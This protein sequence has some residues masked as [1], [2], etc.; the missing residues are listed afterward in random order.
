MA[1]ASIGWAAALWAVSVVPVAS[2][3][4]AAP[5]TAEPRRLV[6][7][8]R[9][10][11]LRSALSAVFSPRG[12]EV[13]ESPAPLRRPTDA[14][15]GDAGGA[16]PA[17]ADAV[18]LCEPESG[19]TALCVRPRR[20]QVIVR[21]IAMPTPLSAADA[22]S[23]AL[24][25][26]VALMPDE[27]APAPALAVAP[28]VPQA[29]IQATAA[30]PAPVQGAPPRLTV[31]L[32]AGGRRTA[33][34]AGLRGGVD[35]VYA[36]DA[37]ARRLGIG[38]GVGAG[39]AIAMPQPSSRGPGPAPSGGSEGDVTVRLFARGRLQLSAVRLELDLG[40]A[41]HIVAHDVAASTDGG[42]SET[43]RHLRMSASGSLGAVVP[44]GRFFA[45]A[46][47][48]GFYLLT[49]PASG[50]GGGSGSPWRGEALAT[51]GAGFF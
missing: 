48:G 4:V 49:E 50:G 45:G 34:G 15:P 2:A 17:S 33:E 11:A 44:F 1:R 32:L 22:A 9:D 35:V 46:R 30:R 7:A 24:S 29:D 25:V 18:W 40:P 37:L 41:A 38:A 20:G 43:E 6:V 42:R 27:P 23:L 19:G 47:V 8:S 21:R 12:V 10:P 14:A 3:S 36:P 39:T 16:A 13:V 26:Q 28:V 5:A 31:E 51:F